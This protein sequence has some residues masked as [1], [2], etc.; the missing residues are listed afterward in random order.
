MAVYRIGDIIR[1][2]REALGITREKLCEMF[3]E[4]CEVQTLYRIETGKV[5][6]KQKVYRRLMECMRELPER[7]YASILV[8]DYRA[9]NLK[10]AINIHLAHREYEQA[11][12]K[13]NELEQ[14]M[15][16][17]Y[18]RNQQFLLEMKSKMAYYKQQISIEEYLE[19]LWKALRYTIPSIDKIELER[20][21]YNQEEFDI[22][23][24]MVGIYAQRKERDKEEQLL[25]QLKK[26][27]EK[28]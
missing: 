28:R 26:N 17:D 14:F 8:S 5:K 6:V 25:L 15:D 3:G 4:G 12:K 10:M 7:S 11:E 27:T 20:W 24:T 13:L 2:K 16:G 9:L 23:I 22:L 18:V 1:M 19:N 21:P